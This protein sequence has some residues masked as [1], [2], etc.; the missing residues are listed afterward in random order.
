MM[1]KTKRKINKINDKIVLWINNVT[2]EESFFRV[3]KYCGE[4][5][6]LWYVFVLS[7]VKPYLAWY[8]NNEY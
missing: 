1:I 5:F 6:E 2:I 4:A 3:I 7:R 8:T